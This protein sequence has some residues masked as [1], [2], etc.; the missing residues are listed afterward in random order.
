MFTLHSYCSK[1]SSTG[2]NCILL[3]PWNH[4]GMKSWCTHT[5]LEMTHKSQ[6]EGT[7]YKCA[8]TIYTIFT[9]KNWTQEKMN[10]CQE[11][12]TFLLFVL[13]SIQSDWWHKKW[14][15]SSPKEWRYMTHI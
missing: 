3:I 9:K 10:L 6:Y 11:Y 5:K 14:V 13:P 4:I 8:H 1:I 15:A 7:F 2:V 12:I